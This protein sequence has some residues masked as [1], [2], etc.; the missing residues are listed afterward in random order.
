MT[1]SN[2]VEMRGIEKAFSGVRVL[3]HANFALRR[4]EVHALMGGNGA[5][6]ST[7]MKILTGVYTRDG[8]DVTIDGKP[9]HFNAPTDAERAGIAMIFQ[10]FSLVPTLSVAENIFLNHEPRSAGGLFLR[11][12]EMRRRAQAVMEELGEHIDVRTPVERLSVGM[13]QMVEI[14]KALSK[15]ARILVM[16]EPTSSLSIEETETLFKLIRRLKAN[17]ISI[18]Y[19]S[20]RMSEIFTICDRV[21]VLRDGEDVLTEPCEGLTIE[22]LIETMLGQTAGAT[23]EWHERR[24]ALGERPALEVEGLS[25]KGHFEDVSFKL[26]PGEIVGL[27]GLMGSGRTEIAETIFGVR[28]ADGGR[29]LVQGRPISGMRQAIDAGVG[30]VPENRRTQGLVLDHSLR[31]NFML[32]KLST[33]ASGVFVNDAEG[34]KTARDFIKS[35]RIKTDGPSKIARLLSGGNQQKIVLGKWLARNPKLLI[36]DEPT[37]GVDIG[38]KSDIVDIVRGIAAQGAAVLVISSEFEELL[39]LSDRLLVVHDGRLVNELDRRAIAT[40]EVLHHAVQG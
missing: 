40:E 27:A 25:L 8:G 15:N 26:F 14:A 22:R 6:K 2:I 19:I 3:K 30:F 31:D 36:L 13:C 9:V 21:S 16:D 24:H 37:I 28:R 34:A 4:G 11:D 32:P 18:V 17:G 12:G 29:V 33:F 35:L 38:S 5:G 23:L 20:H 39:A 1:D 10:E 7:L